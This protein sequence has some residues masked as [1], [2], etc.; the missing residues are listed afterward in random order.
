MSEQFDAYHKWLGI[1]PKSQP[2]NNY[3]LLG[4]PEFTDDHTV[5]ENSAVRQM[6]HIRTFQLG[7][8][9]RKS[10]QLLNE[11][12][13]ARICLLN[14]NAKPAYDAKLRALSVP[15]APSKKK[16]T[17]QAVTD[18]AAFSIHPSRPGAKTDVL[19]P[20]KPRWFSLN[21]SFGSRKLAG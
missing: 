14:P 17:R 8:H 1:P 7:A 16:P 13:S 5:I 18:A 21:R 4:I 6:S 10:Q 2:P 11:I 15:R 12:A 20:C 19:K 9:G 3:Q